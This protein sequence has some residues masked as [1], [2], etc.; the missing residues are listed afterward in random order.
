MCIQKLGEDQCQSGNKKGVADISI[1]I[2]HLCTHPGT[3]LVVGAK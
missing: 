1:Y 2:L 3:G